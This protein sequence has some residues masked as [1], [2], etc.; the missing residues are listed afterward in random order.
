MRKHTITLTR[1]TA[2]VALLAT[3]AIHLEQYAVAGYSVVPTIGPLFLVNFIAGTVL[4]L[5]LLVPIRAGAQRLRR[6][7]DAVVAVTGISVAGGALVALLVSEHTP[8]FG[9]MEHGYRLE[10]VIAITAEA[11]AT[12]AL[13]VLLLLNR[14]AARAGTR[15]MLWPH[16]PSAR[17]NGTTAAARARSRDHGRGLA[18]GWAN[19]GQAR[20]ASPEPKGQAPARLHHVH[21]RHASARGQGPVGAD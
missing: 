4:G 10:I 16:A 18:P 2:A 8:L 19:D 3:G 13:C 6:T 20:D 14:R 5:A 17:A 7:V 9:F 1:V 11:L 15:V 21:D 12:V